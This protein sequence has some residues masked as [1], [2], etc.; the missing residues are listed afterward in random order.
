MTLMMYFIAPM[1]L[2]E[3]M[4]VAAMLASFMGVGWMMGMVV[5]FINGTVIFP[6]IYAYVLYSFLPGDPWLKGTLWGVILWVLAQS[7]VMPM[8]GG[9]FFSSLAGGAM[10]V[11]GSLLG[12]ILYGASLGGIAGGKVP[13]PH[14]A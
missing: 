11:M 9:G 1:M 10:A 3:P 13:Q 12:H 6:L 2:G 8:M 14:A 7:I 4:D 5:H